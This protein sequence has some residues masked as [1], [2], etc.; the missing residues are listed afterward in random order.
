MLP[1][2]QRI[3][4]GPGMLP[5]QLRAGTSTVSSPW[6]LASSGSRRKYRPSRR[7]V[8]LTVTAL[9][10]EIRSWRSQLLRI[11]VLP[12]GAQRAAH[13]RGEHEPRLVE[14]HQVG[15]AASGPRG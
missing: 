6:A 3:V 14:E 4:I 11:G 1:R 2:S 12:R 15:L 9:M 7:R 10:A 5:P 8:G 13:R